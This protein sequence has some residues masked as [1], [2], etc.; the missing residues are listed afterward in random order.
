MT[1]LTGSTITFGV[2]SGGGIREDL[3][4]VIWDLFPED[5]WAVSNLDKV[6]ATAPTHEW[7]SQQLLAAAAN[8]GVEGYIIH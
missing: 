8:I 4:D 5:T 2:G 1:V 6:D 3:E 7:L